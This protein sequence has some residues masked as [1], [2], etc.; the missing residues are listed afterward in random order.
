MSFPAD[1]APLLS[2]IVATLDRTSELQS[3]LRSLQS[4]QLSDVELIIVDQNDDDRLVDLLASIQL[5]L[6]VQHL[7]MN[8]KSA[9]SARNFG[10]SVAVGEW[11]G[12]P[13]DDCALTP[14]TLER[15]RHH[16]Q[17]TAC[18][19][20]SG[21]TI[22]R[23]GK[24]SVLRWPDQACEIDRRS[25]R[26]AFAE[27][28]LYIRRSLFDQI[29]G[30]DAFFGPG[31]VYGAEEAVD[32]IRR[33]WAAVPD[34]RAAYV[35]DVCF[36]HA[37]ASPYSDEVALQK[38]YRYARARGACFARHWRSSYLPRAVWETGKHLAGSVLLRGKRRRSRILSLKGYA[39]GFIGY[40]RNEARWL[41]TEA[42]QWIVKSDVA[43]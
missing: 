5:P 22:D 31:G 20:L 42:H 16:L 14:V 28:T 9:S 41:N 33:L 25:L 32:L 43:G 21:R 7:R 29:G 23:E 35:P 13:D 1:P 36:I 38:T 34:V 30:F 26:N 3:F 37:D 11:I 2:F 27:S 8:R 17:T 39:V 19:V 40:R 12:F 4:S 15:L 24:A 18:D 10:A 6:P